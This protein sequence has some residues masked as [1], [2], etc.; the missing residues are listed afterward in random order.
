MMRR[1]SSVESRFSAKDL[2]RL[3]R[4]A[5]GPA[6]IK[7]DLDQDID[8][9]VTLLWN[10]VEELVSRDIDWILSSGNLEYTF[11]CTLFSYD[12]I[13]AFE[14]GPVR[15]EPRMAWL[16]RKSSGGR[17]ACVGAG[18]RIERFAHKVADGPI[19]GVTRRRV[20]QA[21]QGKKLKSRKAS[22]DAH[23]ESFILETVEDCKYVCSVNVPGFGGEAG[24]HKA[25]I[26][27]RLAL[28]AV[29][30]AWETPSEALKG[31]GLLVDCRHQYGTTMSFTPD[32]LIFGGRSG[33]KRLHAPWVERDKLEESLRDFSDCF[34]I[35]GDSISA[36]LDPDGSSERLVLMNA[37]AH[38]LLW[39]YEGCRETVDQIAIVKFSSAMEVLTGGFV[40]KAGNGKKI[41]GGQPALRELLK[42]NLEID[43]DTVI[44]RDGKTVKDVVE[45]IYS[46]GRNRMIHGENKA[47]GNDWSIE[48]ASAE[49]LSRYC[50]VAYLGRVF[51]NPMFDNPKQLMQ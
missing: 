28:A 17:W 27:T 23:D 45:L 38:S 31:I 25:M 44:T 18:G 10:D 47:F 5:F 1:N 8:Q 32:G 21:W 15:F 14:I 35:A 40:W 2:T 42:A 29:S 9:N 24:A 4:K 33:S 3:V 36:Y 51:E 26:S 12:D 41:K 46:A 48:R 39:F 37:I 34:A 13:A 19:S 16:D 11:G 20:I 50:L 22:R 49:K 6:L 7:V 43:D 30:L